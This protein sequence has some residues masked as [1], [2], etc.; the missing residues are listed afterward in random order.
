L[1]EFNKRLPEFNKRLSEFN[2]RLSEFNK[3]LSEC[4]I[5]PHPP[6]PSPKIG[7]RGAKFKV[8]L[9][10]LGEGFRVRAFNSCKKS[11]IGS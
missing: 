11:N 1:P 3:R 4:K 10:S 9:P 7:R 6:T 5:R 8:P 2:K